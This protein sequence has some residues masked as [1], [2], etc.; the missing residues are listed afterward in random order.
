MLRQALE[1][2]GFG[3][4]KGD[5]NAERYFPGI[6]RMESDWLRRRPW[7]GRRRVVEHARKR[8]AQGLHVGLV[9]KIARSR[10]RATIRDAGEELNDDFGGMIRQCPTQIGRGRSG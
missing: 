8:R 3:V 1:H 7:V 10:I 2:Y 5:G 4:S 9:R 6:Q